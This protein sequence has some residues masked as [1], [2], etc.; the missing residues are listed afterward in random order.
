MN[1]TCIFC[2]KPISKA[3]KTYEHIIPQWLIKQTG[4]P[5]RKVM[6]LPFITD[7]KPEHI[8]FTDLC[9][10]AHR[11]CNNEH[12]KLENKAKSTINKILKSASVNANEINSL[13]KWFDKVRI[14]LW[15]GYNS[16]L[17]PDKQIKPHFHINQRANKADRI[18]II[19]KM[20]HLGDRVNFCGAE[21]PIF[22]YM[23]SAFLL[24]INDYI[25]TNASTHGLCSHNL[26]FPSFDYLATGANG[27]LESSKIVLPRNKIKEPVIKY[28]KTNK[29]SIII[30]Q[31][32]FKEI[33]QYC[34][35]CGSAY[36]QEHSL[37]Y[38]N[39]IGGIFVQ[40]GISIPTYLAVNDVCNITPQTVCTTLPESVIRVCE[41]QN[42]IVLDTKRHNLMTKDQKD[43]THKW[44][45]TNNEYIKYLQSKM[46]PL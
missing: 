15:L 18:L 35:E 28:I 3:D 14:G 43:K 23:P 44:I 2:G 9:F 16:M 41:L 33:L 10:P 6:I 7:S 25:F 5:N 27:Q 34:H 37:D 1:N 38:K 19:E 40:K 24:C 13:L 11:S 32:I 46:F 30:Y 21:A 12:A 22:K 36:V 39:G 20:H 45:A 29:D 42:N 26:G 4:D 31:V 17:H 8:N